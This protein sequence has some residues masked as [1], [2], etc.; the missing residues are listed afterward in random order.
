M[1][2]TND[3]CVHGIGEEGEEDLGNIVQHKCKLVLRVYSSFAY[4]MGLK[5]GGK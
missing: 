3:A 5:A 4:M 2:V 1:D